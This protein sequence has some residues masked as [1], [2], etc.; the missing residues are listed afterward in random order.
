MSVKITGTAQLKTKLD[1]L[2]DDM[3][4]A[5]DGGVF[6]TAQAIRKVAISS[7]QERSP[8]RN[9]IR[10]SQAGNAYNHVAASAGQAPNTD[11]GVLVRSV[12]VEKVGNAHYEIGSNIDYSE[13][14]ELGTTNMLPRP[15]L[16]PALEEKKNTLRPNIHKVADI[17]IKRSTQ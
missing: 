13:W 10:Y 14:L 12:A 11:T 4:L 9:V 1:K 6:A 17:L 8:G 7:I 15:W 2:G 5:V 3:L 16:F